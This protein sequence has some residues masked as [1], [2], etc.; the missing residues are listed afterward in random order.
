MNFTDV[1]GTGVPAVIPTVTK[2]MCVSVIGPCRLCTRTPNKKINLLQALG[3]NVMQMWEC[4]WT[5]L[6]ET[7]DDIQTFA[8]SLQFVEPLE[9]R[10]AFCG[11]RTNA[12]NCTIA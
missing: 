2:N 6:K 7:S 3:Y 5:H 8:D 9:P 10:D 11:G 12:V 1:S 4:E